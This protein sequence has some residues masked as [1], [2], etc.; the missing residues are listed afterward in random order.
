YLHTILERVAEQSAAEDGPGVVP[1][2]LSDA[3]T[4]L[5]GFEIQMGPYAV[6]ELSA[7]DLLAQWGA[8]TPESGLNLFVAD[9]LDNPYA[10]QNQSASGMNSIAQSRRRANEVKAD[11][12]IQVV[13][14]NPPYKDQAK[15]M[16][17]WVEDGDSN[18]PKK[19]RRALMDDFKLKGNG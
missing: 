8:R 6:A 1:E 10:A 17:S 14:G 19:K 16:G 18:V 15:G 2:V 7:S 11:A 3:V 13:I 9:T 12:N 4:R 5:I